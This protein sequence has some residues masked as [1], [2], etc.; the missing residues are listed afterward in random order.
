MENFVEYLGYVASFI[1]LVSLVMRSIKR[2]RFINLVGSLIFAI[3]GY[4]IGSIPVV[5]MN[6]GIVGINIYYLNQMLRSKEYFDIISL[7]GNDE[8]VKEFIQF[9]EGAIK[10]F[11]PFSKTDL[12][13]KTFGYFILRNMN[14]AGI[15]L[16]EP[17]D[18]KTL[19]IKLDYATPMYQDFK[20]SAHIYEN[21]AKRFK[22]LGYETF[23]AS[24]SHPRH[25]AY[26]K[27]MGFEKSKEG[28][29]Y[30]KTI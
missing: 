18:Q 15:F 10:E 23:I 16:V 5:V 9:Y 1:I 29:Q 30:T 19:E 22:D 4:F 24:S 6:L 2:L 3:Y 17:L 28:I 7:K 21:E 26:L 25:E 12:N 14:H 20:T 11:M 8:Y 13:E 27:K